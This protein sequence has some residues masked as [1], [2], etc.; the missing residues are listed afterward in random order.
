MGV[1][2]SESLRDARRKMLAGEPV[3]GCENCYREE[4]LGLLSYRQRSNEEWN[5]TS[6]TELQQRILESQGHNGHLS[7]MPIYYDLRLG[8]LCN[9]KCRSCCS[10]S[11][12]AFEAEGRQISSRNTD[13]QRFWRD[14]QIDRSWV[15]GSRFWDELYA[16]IGNVR[17]IYLTGGEPTLIVKNFDFLRKVID[18]G[19]SEHIVIQINT[20][21]T[22]F[23]SE[24]IDLL[25][26]FERI[27][28]AIS[29]DGYGMTQEYLR[30]PS[31]WEQIQEAYRKCLS[32][33]SNF[34][35]LASP[36]FQALN[37]M[38]FPRLLQ[39]FDEE[40]AAAVNPAELAPI[41]LRDPQQL[42]AAVLPRELRLDIARRIR[43]QI[44]ISQNLRGHEMQN[45]FELIYA[46]LENDIPDREKGFEDFL[47][48][49]H[50]LDIHRKKK[51][52][53]FLPELTK[54]LK[55]RAEGGL[56]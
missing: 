40:N 8:S 3:S 6:Q 54:A 16:H 36:V 21:L 19:Y 43:H 45:S 22:T 37:A 55:S 13:Y 25:K 46:E 30:Y 1:W 9:L 17:R 50:L 4:E 12:V 53:D 20:N 5:R 23:R 47:R 33:P 34:S 51:M 38:D 35:I 31:R 27:I 52:S 24:F 32:L 18:S 10:E 48:F 49:N 26:R 2:N 15:E 44:S 39:F 42:R 29:I 56:S 7:K 41:I 14:V 11:S 28:F